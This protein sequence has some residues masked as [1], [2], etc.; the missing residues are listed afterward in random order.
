MMLK[1]MEFG[2][3]CDHLQQVSALL[4]IS[5][6]VCVPRHLSASNQRGWGTPNDLVKQG[7]EYQFILSSLPPW[8]SLWRKI[9]HP[10]GIPKI[11]IFYWNLVHGKLPMVKKL[12]RRGFMGLQ[13]VIFVKM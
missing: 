5:L 13:G 6:K 12:Q 8:S 3:F 11:N 9:W 4:E 10:D 7:H 2:N 1:G